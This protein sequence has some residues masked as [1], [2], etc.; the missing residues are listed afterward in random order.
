MHC[1]QETILFQRICSN[2]KS[3]APLQFAIRYFDTYAVI[4]QNM[5]VC[6]LSHAVQNYQVLKHPYKHQLPERFCVNIKP[7]SISNLPFLI[8]LYSFYFNFELWSFCQL[9]KTPTCFCVQQPSVSNETQFKVENCCARRENSRP[10]HVIFFCK[11]NFL[12]VSQEKI[13]VPTREKC[14]ASRKGSHKFLVFI[15]SVAISEC[16]SRWR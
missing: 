3:S 5:P 4:R 8:Y 13:R 6:A 2:P 16:V 15:R 1:C 12:N 10:F 11:L 14:V 7:D 9:Y